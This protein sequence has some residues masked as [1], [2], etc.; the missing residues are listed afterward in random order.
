MSVPHPL[1]RVMA[2]HALVYCERLFYLEEVEEL[3]AADA[4]VY[5]GRRLHQEELPAVE[6]GE[7]QS[8]QLASEA[9]GIRGRLDLLRKRCGE[10]VPY[11][12]KKGRCRR[13]DGQAGAW[14]SDEV[15]VGAY[16]LLVESETGRRVNVGMIRYREDAVTVKVPINDSVRER[17]RIA[18]ERA[19]AL[20]ETTERPPVTEATG[21]CS[22]CAL[23][24]V[25]L[26]EEERFASD[27]S[28]PIARLFPADPEKTVLHIAE[29]GAKV[30][31]SGDSLVIRSRDKK[32]VLA[33]Q[34]AF[35]TQS[36]VIHGYPQVTT[37]A[38]HLCARHGVPVHF[39]GS[40]GAYIACLTPGRSA[41]QRRVRQYRALADDS[42]SLALARRLAHAK[43][44]SQRRFVLRASRGKDRLNSGLAQHLRELDESARMAIEAADK[45][46]LRGYEGR[47]G[48]AY[49]ASIPA[50]IGDGV[51]EL[52][53]FERRS[54]RPPRDRFNA[55]LSFG[56]ALL[57]QRVINAIVTVGLDPSFGF[58]HTP[59]SAAYPL[60]LDLVE[61][62][63]VFVVDIPV[64]G[65]VNRRTWVP[66][67]DFTVVGKQV[68]LSTVGKKKF[69]EIFERRLTERWKHPVLDYSLSYARHLELEVRLL[70][71]EWMGA[72]DLFARVRLR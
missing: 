28:R 65:S 23:A 26:P 19:R 38:L 31:R 1:V 24:P 47:A 7:F 37:Q 13:V 51:P 43:I 41:V 6:D 54:R 33:K 66:D 58:F 5:A 35:L 63:R 9:I 22:T 10:L 56:Y 53:H 17:V 2:L 20:R 44:R 8:Q 62:F 59:R 67:R 32:T 71:K 49:F 12:L 45:E 50:L 25:C 46:C 48:R 64:L 40:G 21:R 11:E 36:L 16:A 55:L 60:A 18:I 72:P 34:T 61:L 52:M 69:I 15:Q 3:R 57:Y 27:S 68:W 42:F 30:G 70:E 29:H 14:E 4:N 39:L